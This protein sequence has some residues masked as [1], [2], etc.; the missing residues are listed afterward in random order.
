MKHSKSPTPTYSTLLL[1]LVLSG[2]VV[3]VLKVLVD[4]SL[5]GVA[6]LA[7][8]GSNAALGLGRLA[9]H[10]LVEGSITGVIL[11]LE[12]VGGRGSHVECLVEQDWRDAENERE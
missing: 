7:E 4:S 3:P 11:A 12:L 9:V 1:G 6:A 10:S 5:L 2:L 8:H